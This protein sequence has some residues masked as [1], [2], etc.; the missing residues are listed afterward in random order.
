M[1]SKNSKKVMRETNRIYRVYSILF[2]DKDHRPPHNS[3][4]LEH[5]TVMR[6]NIRRIILSALS[7]HGDWIADVY[8][9]DTKEN[10]LKFHRII[11]GFRW[12]VNFQNSTISNEMVQEI[13]K[14]RKKLVEEFKSELIKHDI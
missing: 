9:G 5:N 12:D 11:H 1:I 2:Y 4:V 10:T 14:I 7:E 8:E 6:T 13:K 3:D